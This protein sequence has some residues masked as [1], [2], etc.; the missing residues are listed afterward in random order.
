M[1]G[2]DSLRLDSILRYFIHV[3]QS[4]APLDLIVIPTA[5]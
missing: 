1:S 5:P 4:V 3:G 2:V